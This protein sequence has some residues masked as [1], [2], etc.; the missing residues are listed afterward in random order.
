Q[1]SPAEKGASTIPI[2][3]LARDIRIVGAKIYVSDATSQRLKQ[4]LS[5]EGLN[6]S[7]K[8]V[9]LDRP[10]EITASAGLGREKP[11]LNFSG[12]IG[13]VGKVPDPGKI[14]LDLELTIPPFDLAR[15]P[16]L[17]GDIPLSLSGDVS[18]K[19]SVK[20][21]MGK[22]L[23][24]RMDFS[25]SNLEFDR[26]PALKEAGK[27]AKE[28]P[29]GA[30][31]K[32]EPIRPPPITVSGGINVAKG[33]FEKMAFTDLTATLSQK[34]ARFN[35]DR[36]SLSAFS[37]RLEGSAWADLGKAPIEYGSKMKM[38][39][40]QINEAV[41]A[42]SS[43]GGLLFGEASSNISLS[44]KG[45]EFKD[46]KTSLLGNGTLELGPGRLTSANLM[47]GA[48]GAASLLGMG[49]DGKET[50]FDG[51]NASFS[52]KDGKF[53]FSRL[54]ISTKGWSMKGSGAVGLD[55]SLALSTNI[56]LSEPTA[57]K[58]PENSPRLF[59]RNSRGLTIIPLKV[60][61]TVTSPRFAL[62]TGT[63]KAAAREQAKQK[64]QKKVE[65]R[66]EEL[67]EKLREKLK[68]LF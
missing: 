42:F 27:G 28:P 14:P 35:L 29:P 51:M 26:R 17:V 58:I 53:N 44:G 21:T 49:S 45:T 4:G 48:A 60:S 67:K 32:F 40:V 25:S 9:S 62:D 36:M 15:I 18:F 10:M 13:P 52:V 66:K 31:K 65:G 23:A 5:L 34:G 57:S 8:D 59:P 24:A 38:D 3:F 1:P 39:K 63:M 64:V 19:G 68:N 7:L 41:S 55:Q 56:T 2:S 16:G 20:G 50:K 47:A 6:V 22:G 37:G 30:G 33:R 61:G 11:D 54:G 46:I 43:L 12:T